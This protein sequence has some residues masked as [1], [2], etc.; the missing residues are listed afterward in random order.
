MACGG[1][2]HREKNEFIG[3]NGPAPASTIRHSPDLHLGN[4]SS[5][6]YGGHTLGTALGGYIVMEPSKL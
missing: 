5:T 6:A 2:I 3:A 4:L 1:H